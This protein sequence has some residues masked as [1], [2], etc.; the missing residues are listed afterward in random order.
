MVII[1]KFRNFVILFLVCALTIPLFLTS[2]VSAQ[3]IT[4][5]PTELYV[6]GELGSLEIIPISITNNETTAISVSITYNGENIVYITTPVIDIPANSTRSITIGFIISVEEIS[7][8]T[9]TID[10]VQHNQLVIIEIE[11][12]TPS[13]VVFPSKPKPGGNIAFLASDSLNAHGFIFFSDSGNTYPFLITDGIGF[14]KLDMNETGYAIARVTGDGLNPVYVNF[15]VTDPLPPD[16]NDGNGNDEPPDNGNGNGEPP[17][18]GNGNGEPPVDVYTIVAPESILILSKEDITVHKNGVPESNYNVLVTEPDGDTYETTT[19][20][21]GAV[22]ITFNLVGTWKF[23]IVTDIGLVS[24]EVNCYKKTEEI[25]LKTSEPLVEGTVTLDVFDDAL[26]SVSGP[27]NYK[28]EGKEEYDEFSFTPESVGTYTV[29]AE[30]DIAKGDITFDVYENPKIIITDLRGSPLIKAK[31]GTLLSIRIV[32]HEN[33]DIVDSAIL[34]IQDST[35][36]FSLPVDLKMRDGMATWVPT[37]NGNFIIDFDGS[38][39]YNDVSTTFLVEEE[40]FF[41]FTNFSLLIIAI[42]V[43]IS[44]VLFCK[45]TTK[46]RKFSAWLKQKTSSKPN[47]MKSKSDEPL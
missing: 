18:N 40:V 34:K 46:G 20:F 1:S 25:S 42:V 13:V 47:D 4:I 7:W 15:S 43:V 5:S 3:T 44:L 24:K 17:D 10:S 31:S 9:Y 2:P 45:K 6:G 23:T 8:M 12:I 32:D 16:D 37:A 14:V 29:N 21:F 27:D 28:N 38:G 22:S 35:S 26:I 11:K 33:D 30:S 39:F 19:N 36:P 41:L